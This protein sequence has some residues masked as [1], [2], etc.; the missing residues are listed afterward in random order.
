MRISSLASYMLGM[1]IALAA[2]AGCGSPPVGPTPLAQSGGPTANL[3]RTMR[4][5]IVR[6]GGVTPRSFMD[7][8]AVGKP[9]LFIAEG[10]TIGIYTQG[11]KNEQVGAITVPSIWAATDTA[12]NV[13][14]VNSAFS[15]AD[16]TVYAPPYTNG[17]KLTLTRGTGLYAPLAVSRQGTIAVAGCASP[18]G[19]QCSVAVLFYAAGSTTPCSVV[20]VD[21]MLFP[22]VGSVAF[23]HDGR[24]YFASYGSNGT[25]PLTVGRIKG[26]CN[27]KKVETFTTANAIAYALDLHIDKAGRIAIA[28]AA[29]PSGEQI[30]I[31]TYDPPKKGSLG[32]PI[33]TTMLNL[34]ETFDAFVF[35]ASGRGL[36]AGYFG[37][38]TSPGGA[39]EYAY[40]A[41]GDPRRTVSA[42]GACLG[43]VAVTPALVP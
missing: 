17:P 36:W 16:V 27:A 12:R 39:A 23:D 10:A 11:R 2:L 3:F 33:S 4:G 1:S 24:L 15:E 9:L 6:G 38:G 14:S 20:G 5:G 31:D 19:S 30:V 28:T 26:G 43:G 7:A 35:Q 41:G 40:P 25:V 32:N 29:Q 8:R 34:P 37:N 21:P 13:Y 22:S 18:S 42:C